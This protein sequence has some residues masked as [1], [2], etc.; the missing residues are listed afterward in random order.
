MRQNA[1]E[2]LKDFENKRI[3]E[4]E[5]KKS[6]NLKKE[7]EYLENKKLLKEGKLN[8]WESVIENI[9]MKDSEYKGSKDVKRMREVII[10]RKNDIKE[11]G[12]KI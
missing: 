1:I 11:N 6:Q 3:E 9:A 5:K 2:Y 7:E 12:D 8:P 10:N 4:I